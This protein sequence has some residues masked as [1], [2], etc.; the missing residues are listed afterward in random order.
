MKFAMIFFLTAAVF[1]APCIYDVTS[2]EPSP[3]A[4]A[5]A[6]SQLKTGPAQTVSVTV[7]HTF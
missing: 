7:G 5:V 1:A 4:G 3:L 2:T 6:V